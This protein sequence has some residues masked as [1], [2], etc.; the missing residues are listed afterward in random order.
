LGQPTISSTRDTVPKAIASAEKVGY[1]RT[2]LMHPLVVSGGKITRRSDGSRFVVRGLNMYGVEP[3]AG[4]GTDI[5]DWLAAGSNFA[6]V[7]AEWTS[8]G[9]N[10]VRLPVKYDTS[11]SYLADIKNF[12]DRLAAAGIYTLIVPFTDGDVAGTANFGYWPTQ[13]STNDTSTRAANFLVTVFQTCNY[14]PWI[15]MDNINEPTNDSTGS[16]GAL[17]D[18]NWASGHINANAILRA[19]G[20]DG[21]IF[22]AGNGWAWSLPATQAATIIAADTN[23]VFECH[24]YQ[25]DGSSSLSSTDPSTTWKTA[26]PDVAAANG[27]AAMVGEYGPYNGGYGTTSRATALSGWCTSMRDEIVKQTAAGKLQGGL[28]W[29]WVWNDEYPTDPGGNSMVN[30]WGVVT[31]G[32]TS[33]SIDTWGTIVYAMTT[34][35]AD[36]V[37]PNSIKSSEAVGFPTVAIAAAPQNVAPVG[38]KSA[39]ALGVPTLASTYGLSATGVASGEQVGAHVLSATY[40]LAP[41][42]VS[43][44]EAVGQASV[45]STYALTASA[46]RSGEAVGSPSVSPGAVATAAVG[47]ASSESFGFPAVAL[48]GGLT[49][50]IAPL[51]VASSEVVGAPAVAPGAAPIAATSVPSGE[52]FGLAVVTPGAVN[53]APVGIDASAGVGAPALTH[54][55]TLTSVRSGEAVGNPTVAPGAVSIT[56]LAITTSERVGNP[57]VLADQR[58][59]AVGIPSSEALG[60]P[61]VMGLSA[62]TVYALAA[63]VPARVPTGEATQFRIQ[64]MGD[65]ATAVPLAANPFVWVYTVDSSGTQTLLASGTATTLDADTYGFTWTPASNGTAIVQVRGVLGATV[66]TQTWTVTSMPRFDPIAL[67]TEDILVSRF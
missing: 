31:G 23:V 34:A 39:E 54:G 51:G 29:T 5:R 25:F 16:G 48:A 28:G 61:A 3:Y 9:V 14:S 26:W 57:T 32:G 59:F 11:A 7:L 42:G 2:K 41:T 49:Q 27:W 40:A 47:I 63:M 44:S 56:P 8:K 53:I 37:Y 50:N 19:G 13:G 64:C 30:G 36:L 46:V 52:A 1:P 33:W 18:A 4:G 60:K 55:L 20:Y 12:V 10:V 67:A 22:N 43:S 35:L 45:S 15:L 24:R 66:M 6:N 21:P 17:T 38:I 58:I 62:A 65:D